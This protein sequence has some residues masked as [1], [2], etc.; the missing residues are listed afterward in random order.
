MT[1]RLDQRPADARADTAGTVT[2]GASAIGADAPAYPAG[3]PVPVPAAMTRD[4]FVTWLVGEK[5]ALPHV[6]D[7]VVCTCGDLSC[8]GWRLVVRA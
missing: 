8:K 2:S 3:P 1:A 6:F 7:V 5:S 4:A